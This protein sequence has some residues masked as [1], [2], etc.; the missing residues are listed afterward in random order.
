M[1]ELKHCCISWF[2]T[3][4]YITPVFLGMFPGYSSP[5]MTLE[6]ADFP[7]GLAAIPKYPSCG[8][9]QIIA[10]ALYCVASARHV[11]NFDEAFDTQAPGDSGGRPPWLATVS[12]RS[13]SLERRRATGHLAMAIMGMFFQD[14]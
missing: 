5:S 7:I 12:C 13:T 3:M 10:Y 14:S 4:G 2:A 11:G 1:T 9:L 6:F 8:G